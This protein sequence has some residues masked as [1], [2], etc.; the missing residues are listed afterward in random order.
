MPRNCKK[1]FTLTGDLFFPAP[2][3]KS[4]S[5]SR[6]VTHATLLQTKQEDVIRYCSSQLFLSQFS[7][8][9]IGRFR[10]SVKK[11]KSTVLNFNSD[12]SVEKR[13]SCLALLSGCDLFHAYNKLLQWQ[14]HNLF[15][16]KDNNL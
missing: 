13:Q 9:V 8:L 11:T 16:N 6:P 12:S 7:V 4:Y 3:Y 1:A 10:F 15:F 2:N 14:D 5:S